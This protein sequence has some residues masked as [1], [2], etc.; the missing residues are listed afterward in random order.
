M[1][2]EDLGKLTEYWRSIARGRQFSVRAVARE[3]RDRA[4]PRVEAAVQA[5]GGFV[6]D[7]KMFSDVS[8]NL[9]VEL[10]A[11]GVVAL[12]DGLAGLGWPVEVEPA[13]EALAAQPAG[14]TIEGTVQV[15]FPEGKGEHV[16]PTPAVPG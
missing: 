7:F 4:I 1:L 9:I 6:L 8:L 16:I 11:P 3:P 5:Q 10:S 12:V 14:G 2:P 13:R 15:T